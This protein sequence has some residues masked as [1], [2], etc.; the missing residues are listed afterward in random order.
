MME[1]AAGE[2]PGRA[3]LGRH[4]EDLT[5]AVLEIPDAVGAVDHLAD[6]RGG[7]GPTRILRL[8]GSFTYGGDGSGTSM[9]NASS[10]RRGTR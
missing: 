10:A 8:A 3:P 5:V 1:G 9:E 4:H 7:R 2:L 6:N